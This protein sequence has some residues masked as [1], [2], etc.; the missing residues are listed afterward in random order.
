MGLSAADLAT[1]RVAELAAVTRGRI[2]LRI[3]RKLRSPNEYLGMHWREKARERKAWQGHIANALVTALGVAGARCVLGPE[4][5]LAGCR[6]E[7]RDRR[8]VEVIRFAPGRR[9]FIR[10]DD[11]LRFSVKPVLDALKHLALIRD[12]H[13]KWIDLPTPTQEVS[14]DGTFWTW[15]SVVD[16]VQEG[17]V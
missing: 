4:A 1:M 14:H 15:V 11:N 9:N 2:E 10:D 13:R 5:P 8:R 12:D 3:Q 7:C 6:G 17:L 16:P